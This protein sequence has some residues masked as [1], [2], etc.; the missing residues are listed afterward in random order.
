[1]AGDMWVVTVQFSTLICMFKLLIK[2]F[3]KWYSVALA[4]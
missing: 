4:V 3:K 2:K 1:M